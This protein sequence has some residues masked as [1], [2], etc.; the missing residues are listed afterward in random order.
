MLLHL[1]GFFILVLSLYLYEFNGF[2]WLLFFILLFVPDV[3]MLGYVL[4]NKIGAIVYN[5]FHTYSLPI[6]MVIF[7]VLFSNSFLLS[8]GL[9]WSAHI[10]MDRTIG[11]GLK[12]PTKFKDTH[13][14]RI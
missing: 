14:N 13:L 11:Y 5:L 2:N 6:V 8:I 7:G 3:S 4:N 9:I 1:E 10:G 12:Y